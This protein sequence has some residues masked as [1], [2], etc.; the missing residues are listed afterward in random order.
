MLACLQG[1]SRPDLSM[2]A[3]QCTRFCS[4]PML[5]HE[6]AVT[7]I[8]RYLLDTMD[9]GLM[10]K[11]DKSKGLECYVD[12]DFAGGW[13]P[14]DPLNPDNA[15]SRS[16]FVITYSGVPIFWRSKLQTEIALSTCEAEYIAL[17]TAMREVIPLMQL[18]KDLKVNCGVIDT[19]P[20]VYCEVFEDNQS[21][22]AVAELKK[23]PART[24]HIAIKHHHF[25]N[26]VDNKTIR[27]SYIDTKKQ[28][29]DLLT[30]PIEDNQFFK[31]RF[32]LMGW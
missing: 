32:M 30:K 2:A 25:R 6:R 15:L 19:P 4:Q 26:L 13:T 27:I 21:C 28:L 11:I 17:S 31:L 24:K 5:S 8:G 1:I 18:L 29:A 12:A 10:C 16:D 20:Q 14:S 3:H 9:R 23:P 7:R 22:I